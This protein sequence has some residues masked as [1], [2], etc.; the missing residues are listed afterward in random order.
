M[1]STSCIN[2]TL[3]SGKRFF[4]WGQ[5]DVRQLSKLCREFAGSHHSIDIVQIEQEPRRA[6]QDGVFSTPSIFIELPGQRR[7]H[8]GGFVEA[9]KYLRQLWT[10]AQGGRVKLTDNSFNGGAPPE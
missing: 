7:E 10:E 1:T 9:E 6:F 3:Y 8:L 2:F 4:S 5:N